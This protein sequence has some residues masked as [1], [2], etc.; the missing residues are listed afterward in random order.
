MKLG[1]SEVVKELNEGI[2]AKSVLQ[3]EIDN[4]ARIKYFEGEEVDKSFNFEEKMNEYNELASKEMKYKFILAD[5]NSKTNLIG[6]KEDITISCALIKLASL[7]KQL[8]FYK[9]FQCRKQIEKKLIPAKFQGDMDRIE[10]NE[11]LY[12]IK[13]IDEIVLEISREVSRLQVAIDKTN[14]FTEVEI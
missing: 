7:S 5:V 12:D 3:Y 1:L 2:R 8:S 9:S 14:L 11:K 4:S 6:Y 10:V 13:K